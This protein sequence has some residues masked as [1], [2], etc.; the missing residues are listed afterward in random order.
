MFFNWFSSSF[1]DTFV[2][3]QCEMIYLTEY[4][5][6]KFGHTKNVLIVSIETKK[7]EG[8]K[9]KTDFEPSKIIEMICY[10]SG[11]HTT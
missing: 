2:N 8:N 9:V 7:G 4:P 3:E 1:N 6:S 11:F 10:S 5:G